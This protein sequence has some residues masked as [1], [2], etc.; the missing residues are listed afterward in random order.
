V[1]DETLARVER[2]T[3][4]AL[5]ETRESVWDMRATDLDEA[6]LAGALEAS[7]RAATAGIG[8]EVK[9]T[10]T[11]ARRRLPRAV[12]T[13]AFRIGREAV[14]NAVKHADARHIDIEV[15]FAAA[16]LILRL[17]DDGRGFTD[18]E[19][20]AARRSGHFGLTGM[21]ER[22]RRAGGSCEVR[23]GPNGGT[24]VDLRMPLT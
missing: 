15:E 10:T 17:R 21:R 16:E 19:G 11:G 3:W 7:A 24:V 5:R 20:E 13:T 8:I 23:P 6:D 12:E 14:A 4:E 22:A 2:L 1:A 18:T 9:V